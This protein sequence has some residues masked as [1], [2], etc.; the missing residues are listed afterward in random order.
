MKTVLASARNILFIVLQDTDKL[1]AEI[2]AVISVEEKNVQYLG[3]SLVRAP[4]VETLRFSMSPDAARRLADRFNDWADEAEEF[5]ERITVA[6][7]E[8]LSK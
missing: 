7:A 6:A 8:T 2:E 1:E 3:D 4:V 5:A